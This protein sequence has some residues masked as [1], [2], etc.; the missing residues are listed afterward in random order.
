MMRYVL[1][2]V[3]MS[4]VG[5]GPPMGFPKELGAAATVLTNMVAEQGLMDDF[6]GKVRG[7]V[8][9]PGMELY[10]E[11]RAASGVRVVGVDGDVNLSASGVGTQLQKEV[12]DSLIKKL[13]EPNLTDT[14]RA[15]II[16]L[17]GWRVPPSLR[18]PLPP[19]GGG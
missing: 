1:V 8:N 5:C 3:L 18:N 9:E 13:D 6:I 2:L 16:D 14:Q 7:H 15:A 12:R 4:V 19:G 11:I 10:V 17:L